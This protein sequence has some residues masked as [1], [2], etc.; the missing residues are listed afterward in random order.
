MVDVEAWKFEIMEDVIVV[1]KVFQGFGDGLFSLG[2]CVRVGDALFGVESCL[3]K[4]IDGKNIYCRD[5]H[6]P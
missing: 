3:L 5:S 6:S 1:G 2:S 4:G